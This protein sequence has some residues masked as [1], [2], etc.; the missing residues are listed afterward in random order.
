M[1]KLSKYVFVILLSLAVLTA[2]KV[3]KSYQ[4]PS[5]TDN[6]F[7]GTDKADTTTIASLSWREMFID[8]ILQRLIEKG[9][10]QNIDLQIAYVRVR[11]AQAYYKQSRAAFVPTINANADITRLRFSDAQAFRVR[12]D[13]TLYQL[14]L[15]S[16]WEIDIWGRLNS[17]KKGQIS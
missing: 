2:C 5:V 17:I 4:S 7:R 11:Q 12:S 15:T 13:A 3:T 10:E 9:I 16:A 1:T 8:T 6:L 14:G